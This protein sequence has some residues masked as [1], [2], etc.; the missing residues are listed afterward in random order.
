M[1]PPEGLDEQQRTAW[2]RDKQFLEQLMDNTKVRSAPQV[3][4]VHFAMHSTNGSQRQKAPLLGQAEQPSHASALLR[5]TAV[6]S[7]TPAASHLA[8]WA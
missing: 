7:A 8:G 2:L 5:S 3:C 6:S 4:C 1:D